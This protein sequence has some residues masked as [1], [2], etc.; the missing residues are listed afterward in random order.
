MHRRIIDALTLFST[1]I[2]R[3]LYPGQITILSHIRAAL[4]AGAAFAF[5]VIFLVFFSVEPEKVFALKEYQPGTPSKLLDRNGRL[6]TTFFVDQRI[7]ITREETPEIVSQAFM[8]MEDNHFRSHF[9]ID[10]QAILRAFLINIASGSVKQGGSTITQQL[11]KVLLTRRDRT[12]TRKAK[13]AIYSLLI[14]LLYDKDEILNMYFNQIYLGHGNYGIEAASR[15]YFQKPV[16]ELRAGEAAILASLPAA[17]NGF[18]P[19][20]H[21]HRSI[22]RMRQVL[23]K[24][25]DQKYISRETAQSEYQRMMKYFAGLN[26]SPS[27]TAFGEREDKAPYYSESVRRLLEQR[28]GKEMLYRGGLTIYGTLDLDHQGVAQDVFWHGWRSQNQ[29]SGNYIF[30]KHVELSEAYAPYLDVIRLTF[31]LP[32]FEREK[33]IDQYKVESYFMEEMA[34]QLELVN[35]AVGGEMR[36]DNLLQSARKHSIFQNRYLSV[37]GAFIEI[38]QQTGEITAIIGGLPFSS[39][40][41]I[42]RAIQMKRQPGSTF[43][44]LLYA[45][46]IENKK[47]TAASIYSDSPV[48]FLNEGGEV[49]MPENYSGGYRGFISLREALRTSANMVSI[50]VAREAGLG[51]VLPTAESILNLKANTI[52]HNLSVALG[53]YEVSPIQMVEAFALFPRGGESIEGHLLRKVEDRDGNIV[54]NY[55]AKKTRQVISTGTATVMSSMLQTVVKSGTGTRAKSY[56]YP[57]FLAGKTGTTDNFRDAWFVGFNQ[58]YTSALW[59]GYDRSTLSL[60]PGQSGGNI[61][62]PL[63]GEYQAKAYKYIK[64]DEKYLVTGG[65]RMVTVC[66]QTGKLPGAG[67]P[68]TDTEMFVVGTEPTEVEDPATTGDPLT[69][70]LEDSDISSSD[71]FF[72]EDEY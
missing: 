23:L 10:P 42:N 19:I 18:S 49:W 70:G 45:S 43:K 47:T 58:R 28:L 40:N 33:K 8:A 48:L 13:E 57:G 24:M 15:F 16:S 39:Q 4:I 50:S 5:L 26:M 1:R 9:G 56:G 61:A 32:L 66:K 21:P 67:C 25:V 37:Q 17:P 36:V 31:D 59:I 63:W 69:P 2:V 27:A 60:G 51:N 44:A 41:Q 72:N 35:L 52:P 30:K 38:D 7:L 54:Y 71:D 3:I 6:I 65:I 34:D 11:A 46:A 53:S 64:E 22:A 20:K 68:E 12:I 14:E 55:K 62:A 29:Y